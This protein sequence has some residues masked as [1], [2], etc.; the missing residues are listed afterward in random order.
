MTEPPP[1]IEVEGISKA[2]GGVRAV[3]G[4][5]L[6]VDRGAL[7]ALLGP[8]G[9][10]KSTLLRVI[11]GFER[12]DAGAVRVGGRVV[13]GPGAWIEPEQRH[14]GMVFQHGALFPHLT[15]AANA[16]FGAS[17]RQRAAECLEL[18]GLAG[19]A[20]AYPH[21]LSGGERQRVALARALAPEPEVILLDEPFASL[22]TSLRIALRE[23]VTA[24]LRDA[25]ASAL[26]VTHDQQE[27]LSLA[28]HVV[29]MRAGR[30]E[31]AGTP[32]HVYRQPASRWMV[33]FLGEADVLLGTAN[34]AA[35]VECELGTLPTGC[36]AHGDVDVV[37]RP[38]SVR[39]DAPQ[40]GA[41]TAR[42]TGSTFLGHEQV[43]RV[44]L[45]SGAEVR[46]RAA[47]ASAW[48][49]GDEVSVIVD[50][51][52]FTYARGHGGAPA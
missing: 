26:L 22:D 28:D 4:A 27:A 30:V 45:P 8:S 14:V 52:V 36:D 43:T 41:V 3:D 17:R 49:V 10:G 16:S 37:I 48:Q 9:S 2:F 21:E 42:V 19:R 15:V 34:G 38:D 24:I 6:R 40:P 51:P 23:H 46:T 33:E 47:G 5:S 12:P 39:L 1:A 11:A 29:V 35:T 25:H 31:Q 18:V 50:G 7:V 20:G 44:Q 13:A 32:E